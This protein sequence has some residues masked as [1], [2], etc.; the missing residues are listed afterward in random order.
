MTISTQMLLSIAREGSY[1]D[2][3][4]CHIASYEW[5]KWTGLIW[6]HCPPWQASVDCMNDWGPAKNINHHLHC[7]KQQYQCCMHNKPWPLP[8][9]KH[10]RC[11]YPWQCGSQHCIQNTHVYTTVFIRPLTIYSTII[12]KRRHRRRQIHYQVGDQNVSSW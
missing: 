1:L 4:L 9:Q 11:F 5:V 6:K 3:C 2:H 8:E 7:N 12:V 10:K